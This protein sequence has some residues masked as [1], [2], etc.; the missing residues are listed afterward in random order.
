MF[1]EH[2]AVIWQKGNNILAAGEV[3]V[4]D[5]K[6]FK[7]SATN[8]ELIIHNISSKDAGDYTCKTTTGKEVT[9]K[10]KV[11]GK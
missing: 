8:T 9:H 4:T 11:F 6:R 2:V 5:D 7:L 1:T 10:L 3:I